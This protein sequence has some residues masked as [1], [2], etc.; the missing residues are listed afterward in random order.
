[1]LSIVLKCQF[2][3]SSH[4][5]FRW[6]FTGDRDDQKWE[7]KHNLATAAKLCSHSN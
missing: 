6:G 7:M 5:G 4:T 1:M 3:Q 2:A